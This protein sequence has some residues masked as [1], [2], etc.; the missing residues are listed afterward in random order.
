MRSL[1]AATSVD[2]LAADRV[3]ERRDSYWVVRSPS[4][5]DFWWGNLLLFDDVPG[6][7]DG[8]R[9]EALFE[10]EFP[11]TP[12][13]TFSWDVVDGSLGAANEEFVARGYE[14][15]ENVGLIAEPADLRTHAR[16]NADVDVRALD[17]H[18]D[19]ALW[20]GVIALQVAG[21]DERI[22]EDAWRQ[23]TRRRLD[24]LLVH[25]RDGRGAWYVALSLDGDVVGSCGIVVTDGRARY[26]VVDTAEAWRRRGVASRL[27]VDAAAHAA[28]T[29]GAERFVIVADAHYHALAL[30][31][32]LGFAAVERTAGVLRR[33]PGCESRG[34]DQPTDGPRRRDRQRRERP[35]RRAR[36]RSA[37]LLEE[38][39]RPLP[40]AGRDPRC[41]IAFS[42]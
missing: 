35:V 25:L 42:L 7:G 14:L 3:L 23:F 11:D 1:V 15:E 9:W 18:G 24:D 31:E 32:S 39:D 17:P 2:V 10:T 33:P 41:P 19:E 29:F 8:A 37:R 16:A 38:A 22:T 21:R 13:R 28:A 4:H 5:T 36:G 30:Y 27:L 12:H 26:Q 20:A 6:A 40:R 34:R